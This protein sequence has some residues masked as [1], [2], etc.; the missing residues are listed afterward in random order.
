MFKVK[1][2]ADG[3]KHLT[4][5][6][7]GVLREER[8]Q[9]LFESSRRLRIDSVLFLIQEKAGILLWWG[10]DDLVLP[11]E[12]RGAFSFASPIVSPEDWDKK[13][14][15]SAFNVVQPKHFFFTLDCEKL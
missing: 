15:I 8:M 1:F 13:L 5:Q 7:A 3:D 10:K 2:P 9:I 6:V 11:M 4:V 14:W 12:S